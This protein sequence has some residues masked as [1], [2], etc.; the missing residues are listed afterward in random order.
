MLLSLAGT[1]NG[2]NGAPTARGVWISNP[3]PSLQALARRTGSA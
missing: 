3:D 1:V 2:Q